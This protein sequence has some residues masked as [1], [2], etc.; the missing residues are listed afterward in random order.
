ME[1][2]AEIENTN[3]SIVIVWLIVHVKAQVWMLM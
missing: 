1:I 3:I 2:G